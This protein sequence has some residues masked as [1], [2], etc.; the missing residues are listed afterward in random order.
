[1]KPTNTAEAVRCVRPGDRIVVRPH[2]LGERTRD[3]EI[4]KVIGE[5]GQPPFVVRWSDDGHVSRLYPGPDAVVEHFPQPEHARLA[6]DASPPNERGEGMKVEELMSRDV[7]SVAPDTSLKDVAALLV[8][9]GISG[10]PV[11]DRDRAVVGVVSEADILIKERG[12][13]ARHGRLLGWLLEGG[14][15]DDDKL[16]ART[17]GEAMTAPALTVGSRAPVAAAARMMTEKG[18]KRLPVVDSKDVLVGIVT[19]SDL[20]KAFARSDEE[21]AR[22][23]RED[24][25]LRTLWID[26]EAPIRA[27]RR[28]R[29]DSLGR[30][31]TEIG[32]GA[33]P[34]S[35]R[36][37]PWRR[38]G[39]LDRDL[40]LG[41]PTA[42]RHSHA[43]VPDHSAL[44]DE[45]YYCDAVRSAANPQPHSATARMPHRPRRDAERKEF[46]MEHREVHRYGVR[47]HCTGPQSLDLEAPGKPMLRV[48]TPPEF[49]HGVRC[50]WTPEELLVASLAA[51][52]ELTVAA[53]AEYKGVPSMT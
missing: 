42:A 20:V 40:A 51:C 4:L 34:R 10:V 5:D 12:S 29:G 38:L 33:P 18:I 19:R 9:R 37:S 3:G 13:V 11:I 41:R 8:E 1:M 50:V 7:I 36:A 48:A 32:R 47:T 15:A 23:I 49:R 35:R 16:A 25:V 24:V 27:G 45:V 21:I 6:Q 2:R 26:G 17:A 52:Y 46:E 31:G 43:R 22:E 44:S 14:T 28:W 30:A 53:I 39:P